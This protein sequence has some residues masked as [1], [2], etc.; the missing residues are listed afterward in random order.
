[1]GEKCTLEHNQLYDI[2]LSLR[3]YCLFGVPLGNNSEEANQQVSSCLD[4]GNAFIY[5]SIF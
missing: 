5:N 4:K 1:M 3:T 2:I